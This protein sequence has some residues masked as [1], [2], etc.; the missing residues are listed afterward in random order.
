MRHT[1]VRESLTL[2]SLTKRAEK[3]LGDDV[4]P[5]T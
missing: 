4:I 5:S 1:Y 3:M 2:L